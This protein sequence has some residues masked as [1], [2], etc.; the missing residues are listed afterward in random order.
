M[1]EFLDS[2]IVRFVV[3]QGNLP[4]A[5]NSLASGMTNVSR[6][7]PQIARTTQGMAQMG[8]QVQQNTRAMHQHNASMDRAS[9]LLKDLRMQTGDMGQGFRQAAMSIQSGVNWLDKFS[10]QADR[11]SMT[12][13]KFT[14]AGISL[15]Q[16][17]AVTGTTAAGM[18]L[19]TKKMVD[20]FSLIDRLKRQFG[21]IYQSAEIGGQMVDQLVSDSTKIR[22]TINEVLEAGRLLALEGFN[23]KE[24]IFDMADLGAGVNQE[25][26]TIVNATR[27]FVDATNG[28][29]R[30]L[31]ETFQV[32]R[33]D[34]MQFAPEAFAGPNNQIINQSKATEAIIRAIRTKYRGMNDAT[35]QTVGGMLSNLDDAVTK[36]MAKMGGAVEDTVVDWIQKLMGLFESIGKFAETDLG[37]A[38]ANTLL[39]GTALMG[40]V[41]GL[42][43]LS[44]GLITV[45]GL[46]AAYKV[47]ME[48]RTGGM[49]SV[50]D[51]ELKLL[52]VN[53]MLAEMDAADSMKSINLLQAKLA[54]TKALR[55][56]EEARVGLF[57]AQVAGRPSGPHLAAIASATGNVATAQAAVDAIALPKEIVAV[58][59]SI[60][61]SLA[62]QVPIR[63][64]L[65]D[66]AALQL[67]QKQEQLGA[68]DVEIAANNVLAGQYY[69]N[70]Q[71]LGFANEEQRN[72][73]ITIVRLQTMRADLTAEIAALE[74]R[75]TPQMLEQ[76]QI[77]RDRLNVELATVDALQLQNVALREQQAAAAAVAQPVAAPK[78]TFGGGFVAGAGTIF[79]PIVAPFRG[80]IEVINK[81]RD[82]A[83]GMNWPFLFGNLTGMAVALAALVGL[84]WEIYGI[85]KYN[86]DAQEAFTA[87]TK[88][89][90]DRLK[91]WTASL[92]KTPE[93]AAAAA[94][95]TN[96]QDIAGKMK[97]PLGFGKEGIKS[98]IIDALKWL[99]VPGIAAEE[100]AKNAMGGPQADKAARAARAAGETPMAIG[101]Q[102][103]KAAK[104]L[105]EA[106][107]F[108][109]VVAETAKKNGIA[110]GNE[111]RNVNAET[112]RGLTAENISQF[113]ITA[114]QWS[115]IKESLPS[116]YSP[117]VRGLRKQAGERRKQALGYV[118]EQLNRTDL[119][120]D[121]RSTYENI[122]KSADPAKALAEYLHNIHED[123]NGM[124][125]D[126]KDMEDILKESEE[127]NRSDAQALDA[128]KTDRDAALAAAKEMA[129]VQDGLLRSGVGITAEEKKALAAA[130][131]KVRVLSAQVNLYYTMKQLV[132]DMNAQGI[133]RTTGMGG[134]GAIFGPSIAEKEWAGAAQETDPKKKRER[135]ENA[136]KM[137]RAAFEDTAKMSLATKDPGPNASPQEKAEYERYKI[138]VER[139]RMRGVEQ[140]YRRG[141]DTANLTPDQKLRMEAQITSE[142]QAS[143]NAIAGFERNAADIGYGE[144][145]GQM[146][147]NREGAAVSGASAQQL[148]QMDMDILRVKNEQAIKNKQITDQMN[149]Q[150]QAAQLLK[151]LAE[152]ALGAEE[153]KL[154]Y[155]Q[156]MADQGLISQEIVDA[157]KRKMAQMYIDSAK[158]AAVGSAPYWNEMNKA[159]ELL[160][161]ETKDKWQGIIGTILGAPSTLLRD[162]ISEG[163]ISQNW[164]DQVNAMGMGNKMQ[165]D[166]VSQ[167]RRSV[168]V[169]V[170]WANLDAVSSRVEAALPSAM[171]AFAKE[172]TSALGAA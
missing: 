28:Q 128:M 90:T 57:E 50:I 97:E 116:E 84:G 4:A 140:T 64:M 34:A 51:A 93:E 38:T 86:K 47:F 33:E 91:E 24:L 72:A 104:N 12:M 22:Y 150:V 39:W 79:E 62:R 117:E 124:V 52:A 88:E 54:L 127:T 82:A 11:A 46:F 36:S 136:F 63:Q 126:L 68:L 171:S 110:L 164:G 32:T 66:N 109:V 43:L 71:I 103:V 94:R 100:A 119:T 25:G 107:D 111:W 169:R 42:A 161:D 145:I 74:G 168:V 147:A 153:G 143:A 7:T 165:A 29:F 115:Q 141:A 31:K 95:I 155:M 67:L 114:G 160:G 156:T 134:L 44:S 122:R 163:W 85:Y 59:K 99:L 13:W 70:M 76:V 27:A 19:V 53:R 125:P 130:N 108:L 138:R 133:M 146:Q 58:E 5:L 102:A 81:A 9:G 167:N 120:E 132:A 6:Q 129:A 96:I 48:A 154:A 131:E 3:Q 172:F 45:L 121:Q 87:A 1:A 135:L 118:G 20:S 15:Q 8:R 139:A 144:Q 16:L 49:K 21:A 101:Q 170:D 157:E 152:S 105:D 80:L 112:L 113:R 158:T 55:A 89:S 159:L 69:E 56:E 83:G 137:T 75:I 98:G 17:A 162:A 26:I 61:A 18:F 149:L 78:K 123:A 40:A 30:R 2:V 73:A 65:T 106:K 37:K 41:T 60:E 142:R 35:M 151:G 23:P 77:A 166:I 148:L 10:I 14:M 92:P